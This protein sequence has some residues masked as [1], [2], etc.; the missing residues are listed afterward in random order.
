MCSFSLDL[1]QIQ[2]AHPW[3][4]DPAKAHVVFTGLLTCLL[5][6]DARDLFYMVIWKENGFLVKLLRKTIWIGLQV[7]GKPCLFDFWCKFWQSDRKAVGHISEFL[8]LLEGQET[9][10]L[11]GLRP[12]ISS[13]NT[14]PPILSNTTRY[15]NSA[16]QQKWF[17]HSLNFFLPLCISS[18]LCY[19]H[20]TL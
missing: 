13:W 9:K 10:S 14:F 15:L 12:C 20:G 11:F 17:P 18:N 5:W 1:C 7:G 4:E 8:I 6:I 3:A 19:H 16:N 2:T